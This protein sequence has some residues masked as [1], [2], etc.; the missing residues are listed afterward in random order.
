MPKNI[1]LAMAAGTKLRWHVL[2]NTDHGVFD[3]ASI[4]EGHEFNGL[5]FLAGSTP[6]K[7]SSGTGFGNDVP[8]RAPGEFHSWRGTMSCERRTP[9]FPLT[10]ARTCANAV[11][12]AKQEK[13]CATLIIGLRRTR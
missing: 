7:W 10:W 9:I 8:V 3:S 2:C 6:R 13:W 4:G 11:H 1:V 12:E 5:Q